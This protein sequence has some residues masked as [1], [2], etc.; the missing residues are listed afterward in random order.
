MSTTYVHHKIV[1][2][3]WAAQNY[4]QKCIQHM[5]S[6]ILTAQLGQHKTFAPAQRCRKYI[7]NNYKRHRRF[8]KT[9]FFLLFTTTSVTPGEKD[10]LMQGVAPATQHH[11]RPGGS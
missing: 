10:R 6:T 2:N 5:G 4:V 1:Y 8:P 7:V 11:N 9:G 3:I